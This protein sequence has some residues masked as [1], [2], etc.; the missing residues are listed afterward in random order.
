MIYAEMCMYHRKVNLIVIV[1][2]SV[3]IGEP[4]PPSF[5]LSATSSSLTVRVDE[6]PVLMKI[7]PYGITYII[8]LEERGKE[9]EVG[10]LVVNELSPQDKL[11]VF[12][13]GL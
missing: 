9:N 12:Q 10:S 6:K 2:F 11:L 13:P 5:T 1:C 4:C 8:Y 3:L 7:F